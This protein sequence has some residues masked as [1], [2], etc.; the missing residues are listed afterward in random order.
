MNILILY[1]SVFGNTRRIAFAM[2]DAVKEPHTVI[3]SGPEA[4]TM[5]SLKGVDL[6]IAG[7]P[8]RAFRPTKSMLTAL[9]RLPGG[10]L[11][12]GVHTAAFDTRVSLEEVD[13]K[14]LH[15]MVSLFGYAAQPLDTLLAKKGGLPL[16]SPAWFYVEDK[17]GPLREGE[18]ERASA[19]MIDMISRRVST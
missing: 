4:F 7:S 1:D 10:A 9:R 19:W 11:A 15:V 5:D 6:L 16:V 12:H 3:V 14:V 18:A 13:S 8:T 2:R 17:E